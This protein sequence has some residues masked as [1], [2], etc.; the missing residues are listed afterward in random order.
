MYTTFVL[1]ILFLTS[2][3][4]LLTSRHKLKELKVKSDEID[5]IYEP[6]TQEENKLFKLKNQYTSLQNR[7]QEKLIEL[8]EG[9]KRLSQYHLGIGTTDSISYK[10]LNSGEDIDSIEAR[11]QV[12]KNS[13]KHLIK[14]KKACVCNMGNDVVVNGKKSNAKKLFN[15][16]VKLRLRCL[17]NEFKAA[18]ALVDWNN[19]NRLIQ[20]TKDTFN[21][22][23]SSGA[24]VKTYLKDQYLH[25][26][27]D[28]LRLSYELNNLKQEQKEAEREELRIQREAEREELRIK[29][30]AE[31]AEKDRKIMEKLVAEELAK[32]ESSTDEQKALYELHKQ[33]LE[34]LREKEKRAI[35]LAQ[36][37]RSG[38]VYVISNQMSFG[39]GVVKIGM[40]RRVDPND[41]VKELGDASVP[42]LFDV[43]AYI[44][45]EN[46]PTLEK[47][48]HDC[49]TQKRVNLVNNRKEFFYVSVD[50]IFEKL[51]AY[52]ET[53]EI[54]TFEVESKKPEVRS[55]KDPKPAFPPKV[56]ESNDLPT[57]ISNMSVQPIASLEN[58]YIDKKTQLK[59]RDLDIEP[60]TVTPFEN[61]Q[62]SLV[63]NQNESEAQ[64]KEKAKKEYPSDI[65]MQQHYI[66]EQ[67]DSKNFINDVVE[68]DVKAFAEGEYPDDYT[69]QQHTYEEQI[70]S[71]KFMDKV[72][73]SKVKAFAVEEYSEDYAMQQHI[74]EEQVES[75]KF[76]DKVTS[77]KV[78][79][80]A[81]EEY[82]EDYAMQQHIYE[83]Q[84][85]SK[86][87]MDKVT[88]L[89]VK[90][91]AE[92]EYPED[93]AMQQHIYEEQ[94]E[95]KKFMN[96]VTN[97][98]VKAI[99]E[100]EYPEDYA[101][102]KHTYEEEINDN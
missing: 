42:D 39:E 63:N 44:F 18:S 29:A 1:A 101:M 28:E 66:E 43:H 23:N 99:A 80:F 84:L 59:K 61:K 26:K 40:T 91:Y 12:T 86:K 62:E 64:I 71:K 49:F 102:Q 33:Q 94:L 76:M 46:A 8:R 17:D 3:Y 95:S 73:N 53:L 2:I 81:E 72:T 57:E 35:S 51:N 5:K 19:I 100:E 37:T 77:S 65:D 75:K 69:M 52:Q 41:R 45:S 25:L 67:L 21:E 32:L 22:I 68:L 9:E 24:I 88:N 58:E 4:L 13:L 36:L 89:E 14:E 82:P 98:E 83:E 96:K 90:A 38:Y 27:I 16:E 85:E 56:E 70:K 11:L 48:L 78:K 60:A 20:R 50:E 15:R 92:E 31:K 7:Y 47:Y 74:Y 6:A 93:Y 10:A 79:A 97:L 55:L 54:E 30:A 34:T 87:F